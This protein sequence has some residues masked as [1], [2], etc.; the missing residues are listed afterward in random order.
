MNQEP[1]VAA[2][3]DADR[4]ARFPRRTNRRLETRAR[5]VE[6]A[7]KLF[8]GVGYADATMAAIA[9]AADVHVTTLFTHF[10]TKAELVATL[11][12]SAID[13]LAGFIET[14]RGKT[15]FLV[16]FRAVVTG[17]A[18][19]FQDDDGPNIAMGHELRRDPQ[20]AFGWMDYERRQ[21]EMLAAYIAADYGLDL[22]GDARPM[23]V[24]SLLMTSA[25]LAHDRW[26]ESKRTL[27]LVE[28]TLKSLDIAQ[29][30]AQSVLGTP[31]A[32]T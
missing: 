30:M 22:G 13:Q 2:T 7:S 5:I 4:A 15:P 31:P 26:L 6:A 1:T 12:D 3:D 24:A 29:V 9:E 27:D 16:F 23:L 32:Q 28:E 18:K 21:I 25:T 11:G 20:L 17:A 10:K 8:R 19:A 14:A